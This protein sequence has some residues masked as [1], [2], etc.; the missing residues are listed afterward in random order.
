ML[1]NRLKT[2]WGSAAI[3]DAERA[4]LD[5]ALRDPAN[6]RCAVLAGPAAELCAMLWPL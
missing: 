1:R 4:L 5:A 6:E 3:M 2:Q